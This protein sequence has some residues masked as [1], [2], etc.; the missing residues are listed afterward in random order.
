MKQL[1]IYQEPVPLHRTAH[2]DLRI[3]A[4]PNDF[5]FAN[6]VNSIPLATSEFARAARDYPIV[7]AGNDAQAV[8]PAALVGLRAGENLMVDT[9]GQWRLETYVPAFLRRYPFVLAEKPA[10]AEDFT[11]CLDVAFPGLG[12]D[13]GEPLFD[14]QGADTPLLANALQ[15]LGEYQEHTKRTQAFVAQLR[16]LDL[17]VPKV[18]KVEPLAEPAFSLQGFFVV[19]EQRLR[20]LKAKP[21][22][23]LLRSGDLGWIY[24]HLMSLVNVE[25]LTARMDDRAST[26]T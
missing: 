19:D 7:F 11:V 17:L 21:L 14:E 10:P 2:R 23:Q 26:G 24:V 3:Q 9:D 15:F 20:E 16:E 18:I 4:T 1:L 12:A 22:Q 13:T 8:L 5:G 25:R 6:D